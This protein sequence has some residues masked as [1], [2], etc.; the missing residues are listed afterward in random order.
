[1]SWRNGLSTAEYALLAL[2]F[3]SALCLAFNIVALATVREE[4]LLSRGPLPGLGWVVLCGFCTVFV[5]CGSYVIW[6]VW[7]LHGAASGSRKQGGDGDTMPFGAGMLAFGICSMILMFGAKVMVDEI[8]RETLIGWETTG[9]WII[10]F[11]CLTVQ[12][13]FIVLAITRLTI[14]HRHP[15]AD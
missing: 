10:L 15:I 9:E 1:M 4:M 11:C 8:G 14:S 13:I 12:L 2:G 5:F 6:T 7:R 3:V